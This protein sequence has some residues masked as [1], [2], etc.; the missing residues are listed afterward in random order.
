MVYESPSASQV[1]IVGEVG[2]V[3][4]VELGVFLL[5]AESRKTGMQISNNFIL[6]ITD[7][8]GER[9]GLSDG[10]CLWNW[11]LDVLSFREFVA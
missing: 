11:M 8:G 9:L 2:V 7:K 1:C 3:S 4:T 10:I 6:L 5:Q